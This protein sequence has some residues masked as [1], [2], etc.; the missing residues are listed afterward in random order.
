MSAALASTFLFAIV[1]V[2]L[3]ATAPVA[4]LADTNHTANMPKQTGW[5]QICTQ[6]CRNFSVDYVGG[7]DFGYEVYKVGP[8]PYYTYTAELE[9]R[10]CGVSRDPV[11][12][13]ALPEPRA[14]RRG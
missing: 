11:L 6:Y 14:R 9:R 4:A 13:V 5:F 2:S 12:I 3:M 7:G 10:D 1:V 8:G